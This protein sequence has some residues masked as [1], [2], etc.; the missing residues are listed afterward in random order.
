MF[1]ASRLSA[2][3]CVCVTG[4]DSQCDLRQLANVA[5]LGV[6]GS[7]SLSKSPTTPYIKASVG[8]WRGHSSAVATGEQ[9][10]ETGATFVAEGG[11]RIGHVE[12][13]VT[14]HRL[15]GSAAGAVDVTNLVFR[16]LF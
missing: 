7:V 16:A 1:S 9:S 13:G 10:A 15:D 5:E 8:P 4:S 11:Y 3:N 14:V 2:G 6:A 12:L